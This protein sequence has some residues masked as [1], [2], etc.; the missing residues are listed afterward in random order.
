VFYCKQPSIFNLIRFLEFPN[1]EN[2]KVNK[3]T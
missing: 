3:R 1:N 2:D